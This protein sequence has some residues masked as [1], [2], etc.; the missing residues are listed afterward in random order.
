[1]VR[2]R[3]KNARQS[4]DFTDWKRLNTANKLRYLCYTEGEHAVSRFEI[5]D[6]V[7]Y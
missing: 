7:Y 1:M 4:H 6:L 3:H 2:S 5:D